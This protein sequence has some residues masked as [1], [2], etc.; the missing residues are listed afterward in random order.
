MYNEIVK[1]S[2]YNCT[3]INSSNVRYFLNKYDI[4]RDDCNSPINILCNKI[5]LYSPQ[6]TLIDYI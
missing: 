1:Y 5:D 3:T 2:L 4:S 6:H